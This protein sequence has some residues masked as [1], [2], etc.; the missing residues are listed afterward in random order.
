M[1]RFD[2]EFAEPVARLTLPLQDV[3]TAKGKEIEELVE[4]LSFDPWHAIEAHRPLGSIMRA[5][6]HAYREA[7]RERQALAEPD[8]VLAL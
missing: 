6:A 4:K 7:V 2:V 1:Q 8:E 5:R 3:T